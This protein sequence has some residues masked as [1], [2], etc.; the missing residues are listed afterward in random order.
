MTEKAQEGWSDASTAQQTNKWESEL[1]DA[2][3]KL[4]SEKKE[5]D[6]DLIH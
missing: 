5:T 4:L 3:K 1:K 6:N 2:A